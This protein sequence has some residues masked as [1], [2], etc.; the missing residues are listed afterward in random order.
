MGGLVGAGAANAPNLGAG[1]SPRGGIE[2]HTLNVYGV[3][4]IP[5]ALEQLQGLM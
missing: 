3:K 4:N 1:A 2:V 5:N